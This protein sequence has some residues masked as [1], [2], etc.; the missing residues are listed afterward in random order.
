MMTINLD[1]IQITRNK[2]FNE[3]EGIFPPAAVGKTPFEVVDEHSRFNFKLLRYVKEKDSKRIVLIVPHIINRP[4]I[5]D[6][7]SDVSVIRKFCEYGFSVYMFDWGYPTMEQ[8]KISFSDYVR[9]LDA[10]VDS[11]SKEKGIKRVLVLGYCTGGI[12]SLMYAS[13][14]PEKVEKLILLATPVDFS[15]WYD[16]RILWGKVFNV[17]SVV[18]LYGNVP[19]ELIL[20]FGRSLFMYHLPFFSMSTEFNK[21]FLTYESWRDALRM[22][23]WLI[24][25]PLIPGSMYIQFIEDCYQRNLLINNKMRIDSQIV[26]LRKIHCPLLNILAKYDHIVPLSSGKALKDVYSGKSYEEIVFPSSHIGLSVSKEAHLNLWPKVCE[27][28]VR[29]G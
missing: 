25:T 12:I 27:W 6:L 10:A 19:G 21:E 9:Y 22:N 1:N 15:R 23:R 17:R 28:A 8:R 29:T 20:L 2:F 14:H 18:S 7:H 13:L 24:D 11:I 26:D 4:Y 5:L 3:L 16:P